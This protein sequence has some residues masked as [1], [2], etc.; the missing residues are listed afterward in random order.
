MKKILRSIV[1]VLIMSMV[2]S[3][4][5]FVVAATESIKVTIDGNQ[6]GM[7]VSPVIIEG[8]TLIPLRAI[9]EHL[10]AAVDWDNNT[11][12]AT[13]ILG[14]R[15]VKLQIGSKIAN[16]NGMDVLL[17]TPAIVLDG[18]TMVPV[19][20]I[21]ESL[22]AKVDWNNGS[23]TV[24]INTNMSSSNLDTYKVTRVV[25]GDTIKVNF[26]GKEES[27][28]L[29]GIDTPESVHP[30]AA[31]NVAEGKTASEY[32][33]SLLEGKEVT[34]EFDVQERDQYGRLLAYVYIGGTMVNKLLLQEG[35][36]QVSTYP[37]NVKYV[38]EFTTIQ[39]TARENSK[40]FWAYNTPTQNTPIVPVISTPT[41]P[42]QST[43][44]GMYKGSIKSDK[45]HHANYTHNGQIAD[46]NLIWF[47]SIEDALAQGYKPCGICFK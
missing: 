47:I 38:N 34:L 3:G 23:R 22:G 25:D 33:K 7:S 32:T 28:R 10:D 8:R 16:V 21:V 20:F 44:S 13:V 1:L 5:S 26:N 18:S 43:G 31:K 40:G 36:A 39:K 19:R 12:T 14:D 37:P 35:Y 9:F 42:V 24:I 2:L 17:D 11:R 15:I 30:D 4:V 46:H 45:Y 27:V 6:V 29:I 41:T